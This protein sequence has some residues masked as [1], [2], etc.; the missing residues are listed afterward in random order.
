[1]YAREKRTNV[2]ELARNGKARRSTKRELNEK[3]KDI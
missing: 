1:M 2:A 3:G